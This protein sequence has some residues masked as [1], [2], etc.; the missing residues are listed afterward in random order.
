MRDTITTAFKDAMKAQDKRRISTLRLVQAALKDRDIDAR[1]HGKER[2]SDEEIL[3]L[4]QKMIKQRQESA[5]I[6]EGAGRID[7]ATQE[8]EE[9]EII[10][11]FLPKQLTD[12]EVAEAVR[13]A[14]AATG[15]AGLRD[16]GKVM[17]E[18]KARHAGRMDFAKA[19]P[20]VKAALGG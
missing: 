10:A 11:S 17:A 6:Y 7:L 4:L 8:K 2:I 1:G 13:A 16:M 5:A 9:I 18:L 19:S 14:I 3:G 12:A 15:A 20:A